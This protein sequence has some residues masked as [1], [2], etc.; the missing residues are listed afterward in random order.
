MAQI[1]L[2]KY[3]AESG[4]ASRRA[5]EKLILDGKVK[6]DGKIIRILGSKVD[7]EISKVEVEGKAISQKKTNLY[8]A[9]NKPRGI[10]STMSDP[11]NRPSLGDYFPTADHRLFHVGRLDKESE[12][13]LI[14]TNDGAWAQNLIHPSYEVRKR[15]FVVTDRKVRKEEIKRLLEGVRIDNGIA[16]ALSARMVGDGIEIEIHE[17]RN[18]IIRKMI[19]ALGLEV[20]ALRRTRI[21]KIE[22]GEL[23]VG[24]WR[25][26]SSA[27]LL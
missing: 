16:K 18:Q 10:L 20:L 2:Q 11:T 8:I 19:A 15:Y 24:K 3:L 1:R 7:P 25:H 26:L 17:G 5:C 22:L 14:L 13:L 4:V 9:F 23:P 6:V 27:E 21:G 12:G